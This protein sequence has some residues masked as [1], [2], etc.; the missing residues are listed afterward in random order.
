MFSMLIDVSPM[1]YYFYLCKAGYKPSTACTCVIMR[2]APD[3]TE[4]HKR[5]KTVSHILQMKRG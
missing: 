2:F 4:A 5:F 3:K 1:K